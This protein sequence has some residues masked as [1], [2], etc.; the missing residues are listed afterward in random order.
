MCPGCPVCRTSVPWLSYSSL[1][2]DRDRRLVAAA[3]ALATVDG[4]ARGLTSKLNGGARPWSSTTLIG[5]D[6]TGVSA[7][8]VAF[9]WN[10]VMITKST[11]RVFLF[12][13]AII[14]SDG[15]N[16][17]SLHLVAMVA[18]SEVYPPSLSSSYQGH[19]HAARHQ[20][21]SVLV[22]ADQD[23]IRHLLRARQRH[24]SSNILKHQL[25]QRTP[26]GPGT[27]P[28]VSTWTLGCSAVGSCDEHNAIVPVAPQHCIPVRAYTANIHCC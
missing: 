9:L 8:E 21:T 28:E 24:R 4:R 5:T 3:I 11:M 15:I 12:K 16:A 25:C 7:V 2:S 17:L 6:A 10:A 27:S 1:D 22:L 20:V 13:K 18:I 23:V 19:S 14:E 26:R